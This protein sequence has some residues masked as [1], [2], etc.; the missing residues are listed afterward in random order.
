MLAELGLAPHSKTLHRQVEKRILK[1]HR[2]DRTILAKTDQARSA[3]SKQCCPQD[4]SQYQCDQK[5][6]AKCL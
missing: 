6:I 5:K 4:G 1:V 3:N 2:F